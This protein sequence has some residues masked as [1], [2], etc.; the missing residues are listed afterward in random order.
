MYYAKYNAPKDLPPGWC[1]N[2]LYLREAL[3]KENPVSPDPSYTFVTLL[4]TLLDT[5]ANF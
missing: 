1:G 2:S 3:K 4:L 5:Y